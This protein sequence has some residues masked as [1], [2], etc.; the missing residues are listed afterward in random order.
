MYLY[1]MKLDKHSF[2]Y[3]NIKTSSNLHIPDQSEVPCLDY[4]FRYFV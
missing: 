2:I 4:E 1:M 3:T